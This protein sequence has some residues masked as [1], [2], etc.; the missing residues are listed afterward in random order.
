LP[1]HLP[2]PLPA[3]SHFDFS[4]SAFVQNVQGPPRCATFEAAPN[5]NSRWAQ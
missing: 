2:L 5:G 4:K 1:L 3:E